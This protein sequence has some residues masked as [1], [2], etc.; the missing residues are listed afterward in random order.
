MVL[1]KLIKNHNETSLQNRL[2][3]AIYSNNTAILQEYSTEVVVNR[4]RKLQEYMSKL[5]ALQQIPLIKQRSV[6]WF[7]LRKNRLTASDL[8][9]AIKENNL[10]LAKK[11]AG[12]VKDNV[13]YNGIPALKWGV[14]FESMATRCY[15]QM[16]QNIVISEFGLI[17][18]NCLEHFGASPD[19]INDIGIMIEIKCP[20]SRE[21][22]DGN[23]LEKYYMQIQGQLAVCG[24]KECDFIE[25]KFKVHESVYKY[26]EQFNESKMMHG[27]IAEYKNKESGEYTYLYS[28]AFLTASDALNDINKQVYIM[29]CSN[30]E[31]QF[32]KLT[33]WS[34]EKINVQRI[35]FD[36][37]L[38][39]T[40]VPKINK[41]W[42]KV[43]ECKKLP[44]EEPVSK[45]K[46]YTF[47]ADD[48]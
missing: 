31:L 29:D 38:W 33:P 24:L 11:K 42:E 27:I 21:I 17:P 3:M 34:L 18:D 28:K 30:T 10:S 46:K 19:G 7:E 36:E 8:D 37:E 39:Q 13:N 25:C 26:I 40:T 20:Y 45:R 4:Q 47:I 48:D 32:L 23:I 5:V 14:M 41:F 35:E 1:A 15:S 9:D 2:D 22:V 12:V 16:N 44:I 43:E 6:E